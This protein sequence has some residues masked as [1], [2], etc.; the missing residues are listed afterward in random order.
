MYGF[1][2]TPSPAAGTVRQ[3]VPRRPRSCPASHLRNGAGQRPDVVGGADARAA[4]ED[5]QVGQRVAAEPVGPVHAAGH[6]AGREQARNPC[7]GGGVG[8]DLHPAHH[9]MAGRPDLHRHLGD[10][11]VG[12]F[13][14]LMMHRRQP[15]LDLLG[16]Q[17]GGHVQ[18]DTAV[19]GAPAGLDLG[20]DRPGHLVAGEQ[21]R[22]PPVVLRVLVPAVRLLLGLGV[23][24]AEHLGDVVEHEPGALGIAQHTAVTADR[25]GDQDALHRRR[26]DHSGRVELDELHVHQGRS[27]A[28]R[29]RVTVTGVLPGIAG[30]LERLADPAGRQ[31]DGRCPEDDELAGLPAVAE[32]PGDR[33][34][35][36]GEQFGDGDLG[37]DPQPCVRVVDSGVPMSGRWRPRR[38]RPAAARR[39][40]AAGCGSVPVRCGRRRA[41]A[42]DIRGRRSCVG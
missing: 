11:H 19:L 3:R 42:A 32:R 17:P 28:Q 6:L 14:E 16:G 30:D 5:Q 33:A 24:G 22:W 2:P 4:A 36:V 21:V 34:G 41:R 35:G 20:I 23:L 27:G 1:S 15:P 18:E 38:L 25:F 37:E 39:S 26:P 29:Q 31:D 8:V 12:Q 10:V 40:S 13:G 7:R 9:V